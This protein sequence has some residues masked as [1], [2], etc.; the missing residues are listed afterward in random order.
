MD[1]KPVEE[2]ES[3]P[4][5]WLPRGDDRADLLLF[6]LVL[7]FY[8]RTMARDIGICRGEPRQPAASPAAAGRH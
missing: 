1:E 6:L 5:R 3:R 7:T 2:S 8:L 4:G